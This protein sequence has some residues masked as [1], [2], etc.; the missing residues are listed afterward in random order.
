MAK[1]TR[2][3]GKA[4]PGKK[5]RKLPKSSESPKKRPRYKKETSKARNR[6]ESKDESGDETGDESRGGGQEL[7]EKPP[8][9]KLVDNLQEA[10]GL[11]S[12][13]KSDEWKETQYGKYLVGVYGDRSAVVF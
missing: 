11:V 12:T 5:K 4:D 6:D 8:S 7:M 13:S 10:M 9:Q 3:S 1:D 2:R